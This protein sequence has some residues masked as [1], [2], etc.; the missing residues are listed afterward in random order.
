MFPYKTLRKI[1]YK[2]WKTVKRKPGKTVK[3]LLL[4][5]WDRELKN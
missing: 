5:E 1:I 3:T 4:W 2:T